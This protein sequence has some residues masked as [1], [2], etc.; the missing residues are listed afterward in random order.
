MKCRVTPRTSTD[1]IDEMKNKNSNNVNIPYEV[2]EHVYYTKIAGDKPIECKVDFYKFDKAGYRIHLIPMNDNY[3]SDIWIPVEDA[4]KLIA[5]IDK[6]FYSNKSDLKC[7]IH[8]YQAIAS[9]DL[10]SE[11][12]FQISEVE[13]A[14]ITDHCVILTK[15]FQPVYEGV[16]NRFAGPDALNTNIEFRINKHTY[17]MYSTCR[18]ECVSFLLGHLQQVK[19]RLCIL[20]DTVDKYIRKFQKED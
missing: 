1:H 14:E 7:D 19:S 3:I 5:R 11:L 16:S 6:K 15:K 20:D 2:G 13:I 12:K 9:Y 17:V 18:L 4:E 10:E 8:L